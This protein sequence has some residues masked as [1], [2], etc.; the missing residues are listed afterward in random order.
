MLNVGVL[1]RYNTISFVLFFVVVFYLKTK[2]NETN[3]GNSMQT[4]KNISESNGFSL[5]GVVPGQFD[6][7]I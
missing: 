7:K 2:I 5:M 3:A 4:Y 6:H 1:V